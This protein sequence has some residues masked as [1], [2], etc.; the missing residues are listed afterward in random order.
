MAKGNWECWRGPS[1]V[2]PVTAFT[3][4]SF[5]STAPLSALTNVAPA[6]RG[7]CSWCCNGVI[8][9]AWGLA[10]RRV[11][12]RTCSFLS[13]TALP[14]DVIVVPNLLGTGSV[15]EPSGWSM[16]DYF[17]TLWHPS[18]TASASTTGWE[19]S[20]CSLAALRLWMA[21]AKSPRLCC[22][23][24]PAQHCVDRKRYGRL[25]PADLLL[26]LSYP[27]FSQRLVFCPIRAE[28]WRPNTTAPVCR[29]WDPV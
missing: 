24:S 20:G 22:A 11:V 28:R 26:C 9:R 14:G 8:L 10:R 19:N 21:V 7:R 12:H 23:A 1:H 27:I 3:G 4:A 13:Q 2:S 5:H 6:A 18:E 15:S 17:G 16:E 29:S 25:E